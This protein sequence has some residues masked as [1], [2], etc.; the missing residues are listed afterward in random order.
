MGKK[1]HLMRVYKMQDYFNVLYN[2]KS[3]SLQAK[4]QKLSRGQIE[5][6]VDMLDSGHFDTLTDALEWVE[7]E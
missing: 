7:K 3:Y 5:Y 4:W 1:S 6:A 2:G